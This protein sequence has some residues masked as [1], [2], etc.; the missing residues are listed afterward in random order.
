MKACVMVRGVQ[1]GSEDEGG[2]AG[3]RWWILDDGQSGRRGGRWWA[4][5]DWV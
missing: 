1:V 5:W 4:V 3:R 2:V